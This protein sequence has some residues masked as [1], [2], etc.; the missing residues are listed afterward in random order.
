MT[1]GA[2]AQ[3]GDVVI[4]RITHKAFYLKGG[5]QAYERY[6]IG[7]VTGVS[8]KEPGKI[9]GWSLNGLPRKGAPEASWIVA[10]ARLDVLAALAQLGKI[11]N[12]FESLQ[13]AAD[14]LSTFKKPLKA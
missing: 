4:A 3:K 8:R 14:F 12:A 10:K 9:I 1:F 13:A 5:T 11:P 6:S 7:I 2:P